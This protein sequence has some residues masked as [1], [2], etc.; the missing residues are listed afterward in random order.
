M[1]Q[2]AISC[3]GFPPNPVQRARFQRA[4]FQLVSCVLCLVGAERRSSQAASRMGVGCVCPL[5]G[6]IDVGQLEQLRNLGK[7][8]VAAALAVVEGGDFLP[9]GSRGR[10]SKVS[11]R[12]PDGGRWPPWRNPG[13]KRRREALSGPCVDGTKT[14]LISWERTQEMPVS[15]LADMQRNERTLQDGLEF[16]QP[17]CKL[18][19]T[20]GSAQVP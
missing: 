14:W 8:K 12:P 10:Q 9:I 13:F 3:R 17:A 5:S 16:P 18:P 1:T 20:L 2:K 4:R 6:Q 15:R 7:Q 19:F 11:W